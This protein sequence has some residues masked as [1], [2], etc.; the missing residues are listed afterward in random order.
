M[1]FSRELAARAA[2]EL[3]H[4]TEPRRSHPTGGIRTPELVHA[5][6]QRTIGNAGVARLLQPKLSVSR[7]G[8]P[9]ELEADRVAGRV[10]RMSA[11]EITVTRGQGASSCADS[12]EID[13]GA[14]QPLDTTTRAFM[15]PRFGRDFSRVRVHAD[16]AA[17]DAARALAA[18][19]FT[20][21]EHIVFGAGRYAPGGAAGRGLL[22]HELAHT[23][24]QRTA[25]A[26]GR[27][28]RKKAPIPG[29]NFTPAD[30]ADLQRRGG[31][32]TIAADSGFFPA[33]LR[34]NLLNTLAFVLGPTISPSA[35]EGVNALDF[36][37][38]HL[39][40]KKDPATTSQAGAA[41]AKSDKFQKKLSAARTRAIGKVS[42]PKYPLTDRNVGAYQR[43]VATLLPSFGTLLDE[44]SKIPGAAVMYHTFEFNQPSDRR[45][46]ALSPDNPRRHYVT[47]LDTN[48]PR[49]YVPPT[50]GTYEN[51]YTHI[52]KFV[53]LID[54]KGAV[55]IRPVDTSTGFTTLELS[56][57]TGTTF[58]EPLEFEQLDVG[59]YPVPGIERPV[60]T[61]FG[62]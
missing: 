21:G 1:T 47:P 43:A 38:G 52:A 11:H 40:V 49:Q 31:A 29:W 25:P 33:K 50:G 28:L 41:V 6:L 57:I 34:D 30:F 22:A 58:P 18:E 12:V 42:Y 27:I 44:A 5:L 14:G 16:Q 26:D 3:S 7:P 54:D 61:K 15:E 13:E 24:Q 20:V 19:A 9:H 37:H 17:A 36:F 59:D 32:L 48:T 45:V 39:V 60:P 55:H 46:M 4:G 23:V 35:T 51:E 53:F 2:P 8:D 10:M 62:A 56:T